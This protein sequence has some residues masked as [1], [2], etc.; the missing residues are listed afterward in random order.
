M[1]SGAKML[2]AGLF[3]FLFMVFLTFWMEPIELKALIIGYGISVALIGLGYFATSKAEQ[4]YFVYK[5]NAVFVKTDKAKKKVSFSDKLARVGI[6]L[7]L[8]L[9]VSSCAML[10]EEFKKQDRRDTYSRNHWR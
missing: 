1:D 9:A 8:V 7:I 3:V 6:A 5:G 10:G 2:V 4:T